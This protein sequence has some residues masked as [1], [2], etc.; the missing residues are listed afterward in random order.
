MVGTTSTG[1]N[2]G[3]KLGRA[4]TAA[5]LSVFCGQLSLILKSGI[6][7]HEGLSIMQEDLPESD[8]KEILRL[9][10]KK[11]N[12]NSTLH[13]ALV[14]SGVFP[15][16]MVSMVKVG[17]TTGT[18]ER[19]MESLCNYYERESDL[20]QS[21]KDAIFFPSILIAMMAIVI[22]VLVVKVLP[23]FEEVLSD[24]GADVSAAMKFSMSAGRYILIGLG[25]IVLAIIVLALASRT[26]A[27][28]RF[29][30]KLAKLFPATR[31]VSEKIATGRFASAMSLMLA[32][33]LDTDKALELA[34]QVV[35]NSDVITK[36]DECKKYISEGMSFTDSLFKSKIFTGINSR[37]VTVGFKSGHMDTVLSKLADTYNDE[38]DSSLNNLVSLIE[39][40]LVAL[41]TIVIGVILIS[42]MLPLMGILSG[43]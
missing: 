32:S 42:V 19:V 40:T 17:E 39:P 25:I 34:P 3:E 6:P 20:Q 8:G 36:I 31:K 29:I 7:M 24:F 15:A 10:E 23:I 18:T 22:F 33:G 41:L 2:I 21:V 16:Y 37:M 28:S 9:L 27:G 5:E 26:S 12:S 13:S 4:L 43:I 30:S 14:A 35:D 38:A 1:A 11:V